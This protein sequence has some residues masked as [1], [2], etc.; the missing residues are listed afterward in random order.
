MFFS[1]AGLTGR[2]IIVPPG[3][4]EEQ[5][6]A[7]FRDFIFTSGSWPECHGFQASLAAVN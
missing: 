5:N 1:F 6:Y 2:S 7:G 4:D 3:F